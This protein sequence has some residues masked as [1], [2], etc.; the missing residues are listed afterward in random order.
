MLK[1]E[2]CSKE[3]NLS[4]FDRLKIADSSNKSESN[5]KKNKRGSYEL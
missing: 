4:D 2:G 3:L 1:E 5:S